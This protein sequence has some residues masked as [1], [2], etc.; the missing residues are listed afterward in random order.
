VVENSYAFVDALRYKTICTVLIKDE[1][2]SIVYGLLNFA[3]RNMLVTGPRN[4]FIA[5]VALVWLRE[6]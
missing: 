2:E 3:S 5:Q 6:E 1:E 4:E